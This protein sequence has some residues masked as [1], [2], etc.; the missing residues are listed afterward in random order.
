MVNLCIAVRNQGKGKNN[1]SD[2]TLDWVV[3][4]SDGLTIKNALVK[5]NHNLNIEVIRLDLLLNKADITHESFVHD[6]S[7]IFKKD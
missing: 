3:T 7:Y 5:Q 6:F 1:T 4:S 2:I